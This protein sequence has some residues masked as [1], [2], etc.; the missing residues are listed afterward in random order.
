MFDQK[1][2]SLRLFDINKLKLNKY[3]NLSQ[4]VSFFDELNIQE[5]KNKRSIGV[6]QRYVVVR[7]KLVLVFFIL[8]FFDVLEFC[9][10]YYLLSLVF[11]LG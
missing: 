4:F 5:Y 2:F 1:S 7:V 3:V 6:L 9:Q 8:L 10:I 11:G